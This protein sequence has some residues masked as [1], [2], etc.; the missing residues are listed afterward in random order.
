MTGDWFLPDVYLAAIAE[1]D[2]RAEEN[3]DR[4]MACIDRVE[5]QSRPGDTI[6]LKI[7]P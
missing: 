7:L 2:R 3:W 5:R 4:I 1:S 6:R